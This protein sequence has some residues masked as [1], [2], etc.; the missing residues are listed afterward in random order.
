M[1]KKEALSDYFKEINLK[2]EDKAAYLNRA[3]CYKSMAKETNITI[4]NYYSQQAPK[5]KGKANSL[6]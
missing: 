3:K 5:D 2:P 1:G 4:K 6:E